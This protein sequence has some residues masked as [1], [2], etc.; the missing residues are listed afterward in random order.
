MSCTSAVSERFLRI[1]VIDHHHKKTK[2][3]TIQGQQTNMS[4]NLLG[5]RRQ[6][7]EI[8]KAERMLVRIERIDNLNAKIPVEFTE[9][10][11][12]D[13]RLKREWREYYV[14][15]R[16]PHDE[17]KDVVLHI[18]KNRVTVTLFVVN[19]REFLQR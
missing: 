6:K 3:C 13:T 5:R 19:G 9:Q 10:S 16:A 8:L 17:I 12:V 14:V 11:K 2:D 15:A 1:Y 7:G 4:L 18:H